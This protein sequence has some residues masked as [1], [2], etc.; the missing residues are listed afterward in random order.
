MR[1]AIAL[2]LFFS[3]LLHADAPTW[4]LEE[5][6]AVR[7]V[8]DVRLSP[9]STLAL[10]TVKSAVKEKKKSEWVSQI[11]VANCD[12]TN[13]RAFTKK[14]GNAF[15]PDWSPDGKKIAYLSK[16]GDKVF[17]SL[18]PVDGGEPEI[19][20]DGTNKII[21]F[22]FSPDGSK[23]ALLIQE[24]ETEEELKRKEEKEDIIIE[25][26]NGK[27][28]HLWILD[29]KKNNALQRITEG[30][31]HIGTGFSGYDFDWSPDS[32]EIAFPRMPQADLDFWN[33]V[34]IW[35][36]DITTKQ[37]RHLETDCSAVMPNYS[38]DGKWIAYVAYEAPIRWEM[39]SDIAIIPAKGGSPKLLGATFNRELAYQGA[40][41]GWSAKSDT[42]YAIEA[43]STKSTVY[44]LPLDGTAPKKLDFGSKFVEELTLNA[45][46]DSF[47]FLSQSTQMPREAYYKPVSGK[48]ITQLSHVNQGLP[49]DA[50]A[51]TEVI[52]FPAQDGLKIEA[53]L[54]YPLGYEKGKCYPLLL[55][56][57]GGPTSLYQE[58]FLGNPLP[59]PLATFASHGYAILRCNIRGSNGYGKAFRHANIRDWGGK[60]YLDLMAGVDT[61]I[62]QG[63]ADPEKLGVMGWSYGGYMTAW[64]ITQTNRFKAASIGAGIMNLTSMTG[65][66]DL[67]NFLPDHFGAELWNDM[68]FYLQ[69]S[70]I[71]HVKNVTTPTLILH[72][73]GDERVPLSQGYE[74]YTALKRRGIPV[75]FVIYPRTGHAIEEPKLLLDAARRN[76]EWFEK[77]L[78]PSIK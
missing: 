21:H 32:K 69:H 23:I 64:V 11:Y 34:E 37:L 73:K 33:K 54:T 62:E 15:L 24:S 76:F 42:L 49:L 25:D 65:T 57:H 41:V 39:S 71:A 66:T 14:E 1:F 10:F 47:G 75:K 50:I 36:V 40:L 4:S 19:L 56:I 16:E 13:E 17:L 68:D 27:T 59:Y 52:N 48:E 77:Y 51:K 46:R 9:D 53:L 26:E 61:L 28:N 55:V 29:L 58:S 3:S 78:Q 20:T 35:I 6:L 60:D 43:T 22:K 12:G 63:I 7:K 30:D 72:G 45:K 8:D 38:P 67:K 2:F 74:F 31:F 18:L 44:A 5:M 70:A